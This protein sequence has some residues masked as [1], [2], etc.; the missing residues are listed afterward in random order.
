MFFKKKVI[1]TYNNKTWTLRINSNFDI[2]EL[3]RYCEQKGYIPSGLQI[4]RISGGYRVNLLEV[5]SGDHFEFR[6]IRT[7]DYR[8]LNPLYGCPN[9]DNIV[10]IVPECMTVKFEG[11][12]IKE[13]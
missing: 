12:E 4:E 7:P 1:C 5:N 2:Y 13:I 10:G 8:S 9:A 6:K 11:Y 3:Q